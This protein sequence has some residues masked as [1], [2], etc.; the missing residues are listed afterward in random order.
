M[1]LPKRTATFSS[2]WPPTT[3]HH[4]FHFTAHLIHLCFKTLAKATCDAFPYASWGANDGPALDKY[5][6]SHSVFKFSL[7][8]EK[9][10]KWTGTIA[11]VSLEMQGH[12]Q[13][14]V[15]INKE[16]YTVFSPCSP[17]HFLRLTSSAHM[18]KVYLCLALIFSAPFHATFLLVDS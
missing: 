14:W 12:P 7:N 3:Q 18:L 16:K 8:T 4:W 15:I 13:A 9:S 10:I 5:S 17:P 11:I 1:S 2:V 6:F